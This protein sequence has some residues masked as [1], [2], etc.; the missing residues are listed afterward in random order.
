MVILTGGTFIFGLGCTGTR[1]F[2]ALDAWRMAEAI[3]SGV[4]P[5]SAEGILVKRF[6]GNPKLWGVVLSV[7]GVAFLLETA[8]HLRGLTRGLLPVLLIVLGVYV[9]RGYVFKAPVEPVYSGY[10]PERSSERFATALT[11]PALDLR[12]ENSLARGP[13]NV[14]KPLAFVIIKHADFVVDAGSINIGQ[15]VLLCRF[16]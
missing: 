11:P 13:R 7:L 5:D 1:L 6:S 9:I 10:D 12:P 2:A 15:G 16:G 4:T 8:F 3:R 14:A